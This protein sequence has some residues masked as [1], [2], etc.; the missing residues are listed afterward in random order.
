MMAERLAEIR[1]QTE[2][3][4]EHANDVV[5]ELLDHIGE[6]NERVSTLL[7]T[8]GVLDSAAKDTQAWSVRAQTAEA[9]CA[10][11]EAQRG[12]LARELDLTKREAWT[13][14]ERHKDEKDRADGL[15]ERLDELNAED[16]ARAQ[17]GGAV[18]VPELT[19]IELSACERLARMCRKSPSLVEGYLDDIKPWEAAEA[20][21]KAATRQAIP[22][23]RVLADG[24][25]GVDRKGLHDVYEALAYSQPS[26]PSVDPHSNSMAHRRALGFCADAL[27]SA[28]GEV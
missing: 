23:D 10:Q 22:A 9:K 16:F 11:L 4:F 15:R 2:L 20:I 17:R 25:V 24:M 26:E 13:A 14:K 7:F 3:G 19:D 27:R 28:K 12:E 21:E 18:V 1:R 5:R 6:L 8:N